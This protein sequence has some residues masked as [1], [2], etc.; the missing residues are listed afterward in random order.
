MLLHNQF[1]KIA[2]GHQDTYFSTSFQSAGC[3][4]HPY[5]S[6]HRVVRRICCPCTRM[7][8]FLAMDSNIHRVKPKQPI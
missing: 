8:T 5:T 7:L 2:D 4:S 1:L 6:N 3:N